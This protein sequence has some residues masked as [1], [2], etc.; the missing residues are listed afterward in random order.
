MTDEPS[1]RPSPPDRLLRQGARRLCALHDEQHAAVLRL[2]ET[3]A[4]IQ[5]LRD[6]LKLLSDGVGS[7]PS[8]ITHFYHG[9]TTNNVSQAARRRSLAKVA[10]IVLHGRTVAPP[11]PLAD[12][13]IQARLDAEGLD[14]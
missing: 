2:T 4:E 8:V 11:D 9:L 14:R 1:K 5:E 12:G 3:A 10:E 7:D 6:V 13:A